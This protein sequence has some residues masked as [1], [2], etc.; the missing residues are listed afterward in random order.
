MTENFKEKCWKRVYQKYK[1]VFKEA[2]KGSLYKESFKNKL[3]QNYPNNAISV[4]PYND[5]LEKA[6][7]IFDKAPEEMATIN[8]I[9]FDRIIE[10]ESNP[11]WNKRII[12]KADVDIAQLINKLNITDWVHQGRDYVKDND[13]C[14]FCQQ[15]TIDEKFRKQLERFFDETYLND[16]KLLKKLSVEY[17]ILFQ[18]I[19]NEL[20]AIETNKNSKLDVDKFSIYL[21]TLTSICATNKEYLKNKEKEPS[22]NIELISLKVQSELIAKLIDNANNEI[23]KHN[24]LGTKNK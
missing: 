13:I 18:N 21:K 12:G 19:M 16:I 10:I 6:K 2:F 11:I 22:R 9:S 4:V 17:D 5:L 24:R 15:P 14:P 23:Q 8:A 20:N 1:D 7:I 3:L